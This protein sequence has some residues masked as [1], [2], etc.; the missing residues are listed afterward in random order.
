M[1]LVKVLI[2]I[3]LIAWCLAHVELAQVLGA[4]TRIH[5]AALAAC[6]A[7][8]IAHTLLCAWRWRVV[9]R[10][11]GMAEPE[12]RDALRWMALSVM[13][14][15]VLPSTVGGDAYRIGAL[16]RREGIAPAMRCVAVDRISGLWVLAAL[17]TAAC[18]AALSIVGWMPG[19]AVPGALVLAL[20][21]ALPAAALA[22]R[23]RPLQRFRAWQA[24]GHEIATL[25]RVLRLSPVL[26]ASIAI[27]GMTVSAV[28]ALA[29]GLAPGTALWWQMALLTPAAM[30][31]AAIPVSLGGWGVREAAL[32]AGS[33]AFAVPQG[34]A[35]AVSVAFG[36]MLLASGALGALLWAVLCDAPGSHSARA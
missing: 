18:A 21:A 36:L 33:A 26:L 10:G 32:M 14:S 12:P 23:F 5:V 28:V 15:Q 16:A 30:V 24:L 3:A 29:M 34:E 20:A 8:M 6:L 2:S 11:V 4:V 25:W 31:A 19:V 1:P 7:F 22:A 27:H 17:G 13:L 35:L 9:C